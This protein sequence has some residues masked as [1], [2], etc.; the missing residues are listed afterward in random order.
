M[1]ISD[2]S[3][4]LFK[5]L[6]TLALG[7]NFEA[8]RFKNNPDVVNEVFREMASKLRKSY[9]QNGISNLEK[10]NE[11]LTKYE[12][13]AWACPKCGNTNPNKFSIR[14]YAAI[15]NCFEYFCFL[16]EW[17]SATCI[18]E[19]NLLE[20][21]RFCRINQ[22][23]QLREELEALELKLCEYQE[24]IDKNIA[25]NAELEKENERL[26]NQLDLNK[27][28]ESGSKSWEGVNCDEFMDELRQK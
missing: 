2:F 4:D 17:R 25:F 12:L 14:K 16:C 7:V 27:Q 24:S 19:I 26:R 28:I 1:S 23:A 18:K 10:E 22:I 9:D 11:R 5:H 3:K 21:L 15:G 20:S 8:D 13:F 6:S